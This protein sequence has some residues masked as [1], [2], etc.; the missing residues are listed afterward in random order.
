MMSSFSPPY[1]RTEVSTSELLVYTRAIGDRQ[2]PVHERIYT[3]RDFEARLVDAVRDY[4]FHVMRSQ[5]TPGMALAVGYR[6]K[7]IWEAGFG[8]ADVATHRP[9]TPET[10]YHSGSLGKTYTATAVMHLA[11]QGV[12]HLDDPINRHL[13][14]QVRNPLGEREITLRD[15]MT[16]HSG[17]NGDA[18]ASHFDV[19]R[20]LSEEI[21]QEFA[22]EPMAR[23]YGCRWSGKVGHKFDYS[24]LGLG[25]LGL[26]VQNANRDGLSFSEYVQKYVMDPLGMVASQYP[27]V[28]DRTHV[29]PE[30][31]D[32]MSTGYARMGSV[33]IPT[34]PVY[35][36]TYP[37]GGVLAKPADHLRLLFAML[38]DGT[39]DGYQ[40]LK[41]ETV[42]AMLSPIEEEELP[43]SWKVPPS[44][45]A[46]RQGLIWRI[47]NADA[48][49]HEALGRIQPNPR[50]IGVVARR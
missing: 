37:A 22:T 38:G 44:L 11:D 29:R 20:D 7:L 47:S 25:V 46:S 40:L 18:A 32:A 9:M 33:W 19:P 21:R 3:Q 34:L 5:G 49:R 39:Y 42:K 6:G 24:N 1:S 43:I 27:P 2:I 4:I 35:F 31:W 10:I 50:R 28:Q 26:T 45:R 16:H 36:G 15:L 23:R 8:E 14:F 41:P 13:P 12:I 17:L 30:I 48:W